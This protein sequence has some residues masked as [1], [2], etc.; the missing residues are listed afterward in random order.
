[1]TPVHVGKDAFVQA[2]KAV[3]TQRNEKREGFNTVKIGKQGSHKKITG[4]SIDNTRQ[5]KTRRPQAEIG[6]PKA[7]MPHTRNKGVNKTTDR[8]RQ[9]A[10]LV[11]SCLV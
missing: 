10:T 9:A 4:Q 8:N 3:D 1:M 7:N 6:P 11:L 2:A 5:D